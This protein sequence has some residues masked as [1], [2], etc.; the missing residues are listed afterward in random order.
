MP[1]SK[2]DKINQLL[3][4]LTK[5]IVN[6]PESVAVESSSSGNTILLTLH[7]H[8]DDIGRAIGRHGRVANCIRTLLKVVAAKQGKQVTMDVAN[9]D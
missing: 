4:Y 2:T 7:V 3:E 9:L 8:P 5:S 6:N 1:P